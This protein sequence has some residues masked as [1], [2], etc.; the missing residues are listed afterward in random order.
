MYDKKKF[1]KTAL[2]LA[3]PV[4]LQ[5]SITMI[6]NM[7]DTF[8]LSS[9]GEVQVSA[10]SQANAFISIFQYLCMGMG[11][12]GAVLTAQ[13]WGSKR[14]EDIKK[15]ITIIFKLS[16]VT[17]IIFGLIIYFAPNLIMTIYSPDPQVVEYGSI[18]LKYSISTFFCMAISLGLAQIFR[19]IRE[20]KI[21]LYASIASVFTNLIGN[22]VFIYGNLGA[23]EMQ[24]AGAAIGTV[25]ARIVELLILLV[26]LFKIDK[27]VQYKIKDILI[28]TSSMMNTFLKYSIPVAF[29]D[30][31][32]GIGTSATSVI[33]GHIGTNYA[34]ASSVVQMIQRVATV[35][36][37]G[38]G[39]ASH[40]LIGNTIGNKKYDE[41]ISQSN[42]L[43]SIAFI[44]GIL[45]SAII[46]LFGRPV[47]DYFGSFADETKEI[48]YELIY[49]LTIIVI[50]QAVQSVITKGIL[51]GGGDTDYCL[52]MDSTFL[53][54]VSVPLGY[55]VGIVLK[56][57]PFWCM[58]SLHADWIIKT[59]IGLKRIYSKKWIKDINS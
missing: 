29:S 23:P 39:N 56:L 20:V 18:Y 5:N 19:S 57:N 54:F 37:Q 44:F 31:L 24:I 58:I 32:L 10:S 51:R 40:T 36:S 47:V 9:Y 49:A 59:F 16:L 14:V 41:A 34:A 38:L 8:M 45:A 27:K 6:V 35:F 15:T 50:F 11:S 4:I 3:L 46:F 28:S 12:G 48:A 55:Y 13:L 33:I 17:S 30:L 1:I 53:W 22:W 25:I 7:L 43:L 2:L 52:K 21:P 26:Y 42:I